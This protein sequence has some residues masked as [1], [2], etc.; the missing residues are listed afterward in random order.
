MTALH[1]RAIADE[2][3]RLLKG[4]LTP[5]SPQLTVR[6]LPLQLPFDELPTRKELQQRVA[7]GQQAEGQG[8]SQKRLG[9]QAAALLAELDAGRPLPTSVDY[10]VTAW[11]FGDDLAMVFLPGEVV[12]D[13][14]LR[15]KR[16]LD[17]TR[18]WVTAYAND[19]PC[20]IVSRRVLREGGY[21]PDS[22][23][24]YYGKPSRLS[25]LVED[26][27]VETAKSLV[28]KSFVGGSGK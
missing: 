7:A 16:E 20:Y 4:K 25:P 9:D 22:S 21:E 2:V 15:L 27:I 28:P 6:R 26:R 11:A 17:G 19:V 10:S 3:N 24:I 18:L 8:R 23:M 12:V 13:Y 14:A 5:V 1:G